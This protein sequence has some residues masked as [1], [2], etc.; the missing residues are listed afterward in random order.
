[1]A[2]KSSAPALKLVETAIRK[3]PKSDSSTPTASASSGAPRP[4]R[5]LPFRGVV[6]LARVLGPHRPADNHSAEHGEE[7]PEDG[8]AE[9]KEGD[10]RGDVVPVRKGVGILGVVARLAGEPAKMHR[11]EEHS[12]NPAQTV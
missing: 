8:R 2:A 10:H 3:T 7:R 4:A 6:R 12:R 11:S 5:D 1:M 9:Q